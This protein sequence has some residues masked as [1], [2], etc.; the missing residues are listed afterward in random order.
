M[1]RTLRLL[2]VDDFQDDADLILL[3]MQ[4]GG[5]AVTY[6]LVDTLPAMHAALE[7]Q[8]WDVITS[9]HSMPRFS[10]PEALAL[11]KARRPD[12][13]FINVSGE[14]DLGLAVTLMRDGAWDYVQKHQLAHMVPAI[15]RVLRDVQRRNE[16]RN[17]VLELAASEV[18]YRRLFETAQD[19][20]LILDAVTGEILDVNPFLL[21]MLGHTHEQFFGKKLWEVGAFKDVEV[22]KAAFLELQRKQYIR[23]EN[24]PLEASDGQQI[25]AEFVSNVYFVDK[26]KVIQCNIRDITARKQAET[27]VRELNTVLERRVRQRTD[28][29]E[30]LIE[31]LETFN[32]SVSHDM[33]G[34]LQRID[35]F[36]DNLQEEHS[37]KLDAGGMRL[38]QRIRASAQGMNALIDALLELTRISRQDIRRQ[39]T[40]LSALAR[41]IA[42]ELTINDPGR[43]VEFAIEDGISIHG[44]GPLLRS[45]LENLLNNAWKFTVGR[46]AAKIEFGCTRQADGS[47]AHFV[48]DNGAGFD[49]NHVTKL[50]TA[51]GRLHSANEFPG[52][53]IGLATVQRIIHRHN[54]K[55]WAEGA[56]NKG[57]TVYFAL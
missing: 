5:F 6:E 40:N 12:I 13:P 9:D 39:H 43:D 4:R 3:A 23:Y 20:I 7:R 42:D 44:D 49:M 30:G 2:I 57:A 19:G 36:A 24:L 34:P 33:R 38:I 45:V 8:E 52:T 22:S 21:D 51:F 17:S 29:L 47:I 55:V 48:K 14:I 53:G 41:E 11:A 35:G 32:Y 10:A 31:E 27:E 1:D 16:Q 15:E 26:T 25:D 50:F 46:T 18:R 56:V 28:Q 37:S 54:G